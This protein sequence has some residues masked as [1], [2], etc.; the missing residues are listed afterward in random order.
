MGG[1]GPMAGQAHHFRLFSKEKIPYAV[2]RYTTEVTRL[3][4]VFDRALEGQDFI[5][6][7]YSIAD[8]ASYP[9]MMRWERQGQVLSAF[10]NVSAW[11]ERVGARPAV[12][13]G[14][15]EALK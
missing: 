15:S 4:G 7:A 9:W 12:K 13:R 3:Y 11:M 2:E 6:G 14:M 8:I 5:A 1:L 10:P